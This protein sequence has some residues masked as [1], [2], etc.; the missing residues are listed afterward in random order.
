MTYEQALRT[1]DHLKEAFR[2]VA[3][4][5]RELTS[6]V[7]VCEHLEAGLQEGLVQDEPRWIDR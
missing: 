2:R 6:L 5:S 3:P 1:V 4:D 7:Q